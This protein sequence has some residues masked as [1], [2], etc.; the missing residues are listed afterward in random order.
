MFLE[1]KSKGLTDKA[2]IQQLLKQVGTLTSRV[3]ALESVKAENER[4]KKR[5][6]VLE[7][8]L[9]KHENPKNSTNSSLSPSQDPFRKTKSLRGKSKK[10]I[11]GQKGHKGAQL[12]MVSAPDTIITHNVEQCDF[13]GTS[14]I[15]SATSYGFRQVFDIPVIKIEVTE[16]RIAKKTCSCCGKQSKGHFPAGV[17]RPTQ[18]GDRLKALCVYLQNYQMLPYSRCAEFIQDLTGHKISTGS[19]SNFQKESFTVLQGYEQ[20]AKK[21]LLQSPYLHADETGLRLKG[22]TGWMHV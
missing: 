11:G 21:Q 18:Y 16:H 15:D 10:S 1:V 5:I 7:S 3:K 13:C 20:E 14:L 22:K 17:G 2:L 9:S 12:H 6:V 8:K 19:L 4:L